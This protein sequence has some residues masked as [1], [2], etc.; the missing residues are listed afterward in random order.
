MTLVVCET[1]RGHYAVRPNDRTGKWNAENKIREDGSNYLAIFH[2]KDDADEFVEF[3]QRKEFSEKRHMPEEVTVDYM[4]DFLD[5]LCKHGH[6]NMKIKCHDGFVHRNE[7]KVHY[8]ENTLHIN[9]F[10]YNKF[11][12]MKEIEFA[13]SIKDLLEKFLNEAVDLQHLSE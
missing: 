3:K 11:A 7:L 12:V 4:R 8:N 13:K 5:N 2:N 10:M 1:D 6:D 9:G